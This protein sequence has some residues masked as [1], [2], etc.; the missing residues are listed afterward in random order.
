[1]QKAAGQDLDTIIIQ[2]GTPLEDKT[3]IISTI[4]WRDIL[5]KCLPSFDGF[6]SSL[7]PCA[8]AL[9]CIAGFLIVTNIYNGNL[10]SMIAGR[11][12]N[13]D[14]ESLE[15]ACYDLISLLAMGISFYFGHRPP[16][17]EWILVCICLIIRAQWALHSP[18]SPWPFGNKSENDERHRTEYYDTEAVVLC[19]YV[20]LLLFRVER[21][22][23]ASKRSQQTLVHRL[24]CCHLANSVRYANL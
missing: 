24:S 8:F 14:A 13:W 21:G 5:K 7:V 4:G 11:S 10:G 19:I 16:V 6:I 1:M 2:K 20:M 23:K 3:A 12:F 17:T 22:R 18:F 9:S 15:Y